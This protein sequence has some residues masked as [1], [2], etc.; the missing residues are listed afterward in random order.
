LDARGRSDGF[1]RAVTG[2]RPAVDA[3]LLFKRN[4]EA[5]HEVVEIL[6]VRGLAT[7]RDVEGDEALEGPARTCATKLVEPLVDLLLPCVAGAWALP[8]QS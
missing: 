4:E 8:A 3:E 6:A 7:Y 2:D 1:V 5:V